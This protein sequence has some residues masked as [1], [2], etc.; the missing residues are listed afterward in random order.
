[1]LLRVMKSKPIICTSISAGTT[2]E[3]LTRMKKAKSRGSDIAEL[4]IDFLKK[5]N[6]EDIKSIITKSELPLVVTNRNR[7][8]GGLFSNGE[9]PRLSILL[10]AIEARPTFV[11]IELATDIKDRSNIMKS[12]RRNNVGIICSYHDF[13]GTPEVDKITELYDKICSTGADIAKLVFT[14]RNNKDV[15]NILNATRKLL[16]KKIPFTI[17]GMGL[18]GQTTRVLSPLLGS[19]LTYSSLYNSENNLGQLS[20]DKT[21]TFFNMMEKKGWN[22][23]RNRSDELIHLAMIELNDDGSYPFASIDWLIKS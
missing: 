12:A 7:E 17:F 15:R 22:R 4:R 11:D 5:K 10:S 21:R 14:A 3:Y 16:S 20:L 9:K 18:K 2:R 19:S 23:L 8:T 13:H 1:M 6:A